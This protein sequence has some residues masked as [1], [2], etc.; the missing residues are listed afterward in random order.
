MAAG[1]AV[2]VGWRDTSSRRRLKE[3][4]KGVKPFDA[5]SIAA[6]DA[7][8]RGP[9]ASVR[10]TRKAP[11]RGSKRHLESWPEPERARSGLFGRE[12]HALVCLD[13]I[14]RELMPRLEALD[15][16]RAARLSATG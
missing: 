4:L 5:W 9:P 2:G 12:R 3:A 15:L 10:Q 1:R 14:R 11:S 16:A 7:R 13:A 6:C 8:A